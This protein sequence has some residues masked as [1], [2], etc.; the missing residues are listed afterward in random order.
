M[1]KFNHFFILKFKFNQTEFPIK[2]L[3]L[4]IF[5]TI[6][7]KNIFLFFSNKGNCKNLY[8]FFS[9]NK[10][11]VKKLLLRSRNRKRLNKQ[12]NCIFVTLF[13]HKSTFLK[14]FKIQKIPQTFSKMAS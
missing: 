9:K 8:Y 4:F 3:F 10:K 14:Y 2:K 12:S 13:Q 5:K 7:I 1:F 6:K 11:N